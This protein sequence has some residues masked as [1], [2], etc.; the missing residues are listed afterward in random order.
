MMQPKQR[1]SQPPWIAQIS[2]TIASRGEKLSIVP[3]HGFPLP[4]PILWDLRGIFVAAEILV[5]GPFTF[6]PQPFWQA[7]LVVRALHHRRVTAHVCT[8]LPGLVR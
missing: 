4:C 6:P 1:R 8:M 2:R 7:V 3:R 5:V